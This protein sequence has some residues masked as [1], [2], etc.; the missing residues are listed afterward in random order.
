MTSNTSIKLFGLEVRVARAAHGGLP[1]K[2]LLSILL[3]VFCCLQWFTACFDKPDLPK[4]PLA[5]PFDTQTAGFKIETDFRVSEFSSYRFAFVLGFKEADSTDRERVKKLAGEYG[6]G[7]DGKLLNPGVSIPV[8]IRINA[9]RPSALETIYTKDFS[10]AENYAA[11]DTY[12]RSEITS[13]KL[14]PGTYHL[15]IENLKKIPELLG[16]A[17]TV[18]VTDDPKS[19]S[20]PD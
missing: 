19:T 18:A 7:K 1:F 20:I 14:K 16:T 10:D 6:R 12:F 15:S 13:L 9:I 2:R 3:T 5:F 8:R 4:I 11:G 17:V